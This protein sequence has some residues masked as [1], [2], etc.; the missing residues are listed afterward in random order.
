MIKTQQ[1]HNNT[2][3]ENLTVSIAVEML[4][5][6]VINEEMGRFVFADDLFTFFL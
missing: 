2:I 3:V 1:V 5:L 4:E 6:V